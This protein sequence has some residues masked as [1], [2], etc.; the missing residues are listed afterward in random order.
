MGIAKKPAIYLVIV[1]LLFC[2]GTASAQQDGSPTRAVGAIPFKLSGGFLILVEGRIGTLCKLRFIV[3]TGR[4]EA[5]W[6][7]K[8]RRSC[9]FRAIQRRCLISTKS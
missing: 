7:G 8:S 5:S 1:G 2:A 3:D 9:C 4:L 6:I